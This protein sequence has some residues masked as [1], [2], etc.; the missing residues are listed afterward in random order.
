MNIREHILALRRE[1][2]QIDTVI[3]ALERLATTEFPGRSNRGRKSMGAE[4]R[5]EVSARMKRYWASRKK[6][7]E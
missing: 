6:K 3:A 4:E 5:K 1:V 2:A 7:R